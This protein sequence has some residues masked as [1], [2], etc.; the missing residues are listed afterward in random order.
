M[1]DIFDILENFESLDDNLILFNFPLIG[2]LDYLRLIVSPLDEL[3]ITET[4]LYFSTLLT[5]FITL[6]SFKNICLESSLLFKGLLS[7]IELLIIEILSLFYKLN[8][9]LS[10]FELKFK[11]FFIF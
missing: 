9:F 11:Y 3:D 4:L 8:F 5:F 10:F 7:V 6:T 2:L 1:F